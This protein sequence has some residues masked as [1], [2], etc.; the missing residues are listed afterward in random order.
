MLLGILCGLAFFAAVMLCVGTGAFDTFAF[1]WQLPAGFVGAFLALIILCFLTL[2]LICKFID[3]DKPKEKDKPWFRW[4][5]LEIIDVI[6]ALLRVRVRTEGFEKLPKEGRYLM[7]CNHLNNID[8]AFLLR[9]FRGHCLAIVGK[10]EAK[11]MFLIGKVMSMLLCPF[12]NRENDREALKTILH[13]IS[14]LKSDTASVGIFPEGRINKYRK[15][16]HF[17]PGVFKMAQK[18]KVPIVVCTLQGTNEVLKRAAKLKSSAVD[19][20]LLEVIPVEAFEGK[21]T[22]EIAEYVYSL[23]AKD[24]GPEKVLTPEEEENA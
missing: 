3:P 18:A 17:R 13:C 4:M 22:V 23:M 21:N 14:M 1:L 12:I 20:H 10:R 16:A 2:V 11:D 24:L 8:P 15:L 9:C 5:V 7:V 19:V 6:F